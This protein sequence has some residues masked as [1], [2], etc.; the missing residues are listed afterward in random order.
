MHGA[1]SSLRCTQIKV[2]VSVHCNMPA[3][4]A[5]SLAILYSS[6]F[7]GPYP[8]LP[9]ATAAC[10]SSTHCYHQRQSQAGAVAS[11]HA[12]QAGFDT[13]HTHLGCGSRGRASSLAR[14]SQHQLGLVRKTPQT[15]LRRMAWK[16]AQLPPVCLSAALMTQPPLPLPA[17]PA[18]QGHRTLRLDPAAAQVQPTIRSATA[19]AWCLCLL[20]KHLTALQRQC[21]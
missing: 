3:T 19:Y 14:P 4:H 11:S 21:H 7:N 6:P 18:H 17:H 5:S 13:Q 8:M 10:L 1:A 9:G 20:M 15:S 16:P 12:L 2:G